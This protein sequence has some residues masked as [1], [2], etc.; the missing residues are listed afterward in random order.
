MEVVLEVLGT[1]NNVLSRERYAKGLVRIGRGYGNDLIINDEH[2]DVEHAE[3]R[4]DE[5]G[6]L[7]LEDLDS[8]N[9]VRLAKTRELTSRSLVSSGDMFL[10]GRNKL[11]VY[12]SDHPMPAAV[13]IRPIESFLLWLGRP[14]ILVCLLLFYLLT[15]FASAYHTTTKE[16]D[17]SSFLG[18]NVIGALTFAG[19]AAGVYFLSVLFRRSG[20]FPSHLSVLLFVALYSAFSTLLLNLFRFNGGDHLYGVIAALDT[21]NGHFIVFLYLWS[22]LYLAFNFSMRRR[23]L[24][25]AGVV[26]LMVFFTVI[27]ERSIAGF[28]GVPSFPEERVFLPPAL[29]IASPIPADVFLARALERFAV[30][31]ELR[32]EALEELEVH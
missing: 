18:N 32:Q 23:T 17:W 12:F 15:A 10:I 31:D 16:F 8:V 29:Q 25:S 22:V 6:R 28:R 24:I 26:T 2:T 19:L 14:P 5:Q 4:V 7:W 1:T 20:N 30:V 21:A 9:G 11:R 3:L 13:P 27:Q